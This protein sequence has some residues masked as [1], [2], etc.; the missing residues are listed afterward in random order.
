MHL[1]IFRLLVLPM[2]ELLLVLP[3]FVFFIATESPSNIFIAAAAPVFI[4]VVSPNIFPAA[5]VL[6]P[7]ALAHVV[8][9]VDAFANVFVASDASNDLINA[10]VHDTLKYR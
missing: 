3:S 10:A 9:A 7:A 1:Q 2:F 4:A 5:N 6:F 8:N